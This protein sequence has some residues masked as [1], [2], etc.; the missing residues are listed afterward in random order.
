MLQ[1]QGHVGRS[2][3]TGEGLEPCSGMQGP[4]PNASASSSALVCIGAGQLTT[5]AKA[6][7]SQALLSK[8]NKECPSNLSHSESLQEVTEVCISRGQAKELAQLYE[9]ITQAARVSL[10]HMKHAAFAAI[11]ELKSCIALDAASDSRLAWLESQVVQDI[12]L[13][14]FAAPAGQTKFVEKAGCL[15]AVCLKILA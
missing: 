3:E 2:L 12:Q 8:Q 15:T 11:P 7:D 5:A 6:T 1:G 4:L 13:S 10:N 9:G 14:G